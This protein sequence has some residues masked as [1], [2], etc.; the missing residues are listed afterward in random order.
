[1]FCCRFSTRPSGCS[2]D[3]ERFIGVDDQYTCSRLM[4]GIQGFLRVVV[5]DEFTTTEGAMSSTE[6]LITTT[7]VTEFSTEA[8]T[9]KRVE[10]SAEAVNTNGLEISTEEVTIAAQSLTEVTI[11][12]PPTTVVTSTTT[13]K[14]TTS[15]GTLVKKS[16]DLD[17]VPMN[18]TDFEHNNLIEKRGVKVDEFKADVGSTTEVGVAAES[19]NVEE[20]VVVNK[21]KSEASSTTPSGETTTG[22]VEVFAK[23]GGESTTTT[24]EKAAAT[25]D[26]FEVDFEVDKKKQD[27]GK[28]ESG[29]SGKGSSEEDTLPLEEHSGGLSGRSDDGKMSGMPYDVKPVG[30]KTVAPKLKQKVKEGNEDVNEGSEEDTLPIVD[31]GIEIPGVAM[32]A[33]R[34]DDLR[35]GLEMGVGQVGFGLK[36]EVVDWS[37]EKDELGGPWMSGEEGSVEEGLGVVDARGWGIEEWIEMVRNAFSFEDFCDDW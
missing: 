30:F 36:V 21:S 18:D 22:G 11:D 9:T 10:I 13:E 6:D 16:L 7:D 28:R 19:S 17:Q 4:S 3:Q 24:T 37:S 33:G 14:I 26:D 1:M 27:V 5:E 34:T 35:G 31:E 29:K 2:S 23:E 12:S 8:D 20:V 25:E 15:E 32:L